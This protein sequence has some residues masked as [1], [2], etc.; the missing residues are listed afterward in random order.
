MKAFFIKNYIAVAVVAVVLVGGAAYWYVSSS[1]APSFGAVTV[2]KGDV[3]ESVD[4]PGNVLTEHSAD[5]SFQESGQIARVGVSEGS[6]VGAGTVLA[7]LDASQLSAAR[8]QADAAVSTAQA[9]LDQ[10]TSGTR[11][12]QLQINQSAVAS[13]RTSLGIAVGNAYSAA[14]DAIENQADNLFSSPKTNNPTFLVPN[15]DSQ[16]QNNLQSQRVVIGAALT[17]WYKALSAS[18]SDPAALSGTADGVLQQIQSYLN[19]VSLAVNGAPASASLSPST[20]AAYKGYV[21]AAR[22]ETQGSITALSGTESALT[23]AENQLSLAQAG[24]TPQAVKAQQ[25]VVA[26]AEAAAAAA[27][28]ALDH[29]SLVAPFAGTVQNLTAQAGQVVSAGA[30]VM[31]LVNSGGIKI[32]TYVSQSD[33]AKIKTGDKANVTLDAFGT[34]TVF[35]A[36]VTTIDAAQS[37]VNGASA[38]LVTLHFTDP[39]SRIKDGMTA[40]VH[41]I[42]AEHDGVV[43]VPSNLVI[44]D[45]DSHFILVES[46]GGAEKRPVTIGVVGDNGTTEIVSGLNVGEQIVR[47]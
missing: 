2:A 31:T 8:Q 22:T 16:T 18:G 39:D 15:S 46:A 47:F 26:Q 40:N 6:V 9:Q 23:T 28:V 10:L 5:L 19:T 27:Q 38:Y 43:A 42:A 41:I 12:E 24:A 11:P 29:S 34:G 44:N 3:I 17:N 32:E 36:T 25:A 33:V 21:S 7:S 37:E 35:P 45:G 20:L 4:E 30:P 13:A 1:A 14:D